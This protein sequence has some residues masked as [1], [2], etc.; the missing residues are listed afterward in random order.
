[1]GSDLSVFLTGEIPVRLSKE[2]DVAL[3]VRAG[4]V[5]ILMTG[6][7]KEQ[8][9]RGVESC[10][11]LIA[12]GIECQRYGP[13]WGE[14]V[15]LTAS[16][17]KRLEVVSLRLEVA[18][19]AL[20]QRDLLQLQMGSSPDQVTIEESIFNWSRPQFSLGVYY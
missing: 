3:G 10:D 2:L 5:K 16:L 1:M 15:A 18:L 14:T 20:N 9:L 17:Q 6:D 7:L 12:D 11:R 4:A 8:F 13:Q 19:T